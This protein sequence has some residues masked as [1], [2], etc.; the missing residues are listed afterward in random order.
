M[1]MARPEGK[2]QG[3]KKL[4]IWDSGTDGC[5]PIVIALD[6]ALPA[7][8]TFGEGGAGPGPRVESPTS[9]SRAA[10]PGANPDG[11]Q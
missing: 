7:F 3:T 5:E 11:L 2:L 9:P 1:K 10:C 4:K 8:T 6:E